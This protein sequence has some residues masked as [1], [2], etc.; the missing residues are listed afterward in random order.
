VKIRSH[1]AIGRELGR[2]L[3]VATAIGMV[4]FGLVVGI[5][6]YIHEINDDTP[7]DP[8]LEILQEI[9]V[10]FAFALPIGVG[11]SLLIGRRLTHPTTERLDVVI[12]TASRLTGE[13]LDERLPVGPTGDALDD[14]AVALNGAFARIEA[15]VGAQRQFAADASHELRTPIAVMLAN[16]EV[17]RRKPRANEH[18]EHVADGVLDEL[19]RVIGLVDKL[20]M[21]A[22]TGETGLHRAETDVRAIADLA[23]ERAKVLAL[24]RGVSVE[25]LDSEPMMADIDGD[26][27]SMVIDNLLR[28]AIDHSVVG[29]AIL[30]RLE[31]DRRLVVEDR[32]PGVPTALKER[33]FQPFAR[34]NHRVTDRAAGSG[35]GLGLAICKRIIDG[36]G[37][38]ICVE[39]RDGGGAR[40]VVTLA[41]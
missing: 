40:F 39:D 15:G 20:L 11:L 31:S 18:W 21:L 27:I 13:R 37:G 8:P 32:G 16:L 14:L 9:A 36:H 10:G 25:L 24:P 7:D 1:G 4:V 23:V 26:A 5:A 28:N 30:V 41:S 33:I 22:R 29:E 34:G 35:M 38:S 6:I 2:S 17:A 19:R 3:A 12:A